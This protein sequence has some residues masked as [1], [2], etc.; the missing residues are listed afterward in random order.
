MKKQNVIHA[1][2][3]PDCAH[4]RKTDASN[5]SPISEEHQQPHSGTRSGYQTAVGAP[6]GGVA[7]SAVCGGA[8]VLWLAALSVH[9]VRIQNGDRPEEAGPVDSGTKRSASASRA[10][11]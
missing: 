1:R 5:R 7:R 9:S 6:G 4:G 8:S 2:A 11:S 10:T 3:A